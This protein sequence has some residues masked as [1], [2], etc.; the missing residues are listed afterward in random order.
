[1][2][3]IIIIQMKKKLKLTVLGLLLMS[4]APFCTSQDEDQTKQEHPQNIIF[5]IGDGMGVAHMYAGMTRNHGSLNLEKITHLGLQKTYSADSYI[6]DS[7][8]SGTAMATGKKTGNGIIGLDTNGVVLKTILEIAEDNGLATGLISTSAIT[9]AT[10]ASFIAHVQSRYMYEEIASDFLKTDIDVFIGGGI[11][12]FVKRKDSLNL[13]DELK[14]KG[15]QVFYD[16]EQISKV[17][18]GKL[19]GLTAEVHNPTYLEGRG[20][21]LPLAT[22]TAL[23]ILEK[24]SDG[25][26]LMIEASQID[27]GGHAN[28][29]EYIISEMLDFD[30][31]IA[32][33][34]NFAEK[35]GNTLVVI[36][37][38]H[39]TGGMS[40]VGGDFKSGEVMAQYG[41][42]GHSSVPVLVYAFGPGAE[43]FS[44]IYENTEIFEKFLKL[45]GFKNE[46]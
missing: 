28:D 1:M 13:V 39:E 30:K 31:A 43:E 36:T 44:G 38:D 42:K 12:H 46:D 10:P 3:L 37:A 4:I 17:S 33:V 29:T 34:L 41:T 27:W 35:N 21:M 26:F 14:S 2:K 15:Y 6:T 5:M 40:V 45:Y 8:A 23:N 25:F 11:D 32:E 20:A 9:H 19:A 22:K 16:M 7:A 18:S 24:D